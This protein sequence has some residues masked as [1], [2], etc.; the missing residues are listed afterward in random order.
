MRGK[1]SARDCRPIPRASISSTWVRTSI[2]PWWR[3]GSTGAASR[4]GSVSASFDSYN[5]GVM[6]K[7]IIMGI[8]GCGKGTQAKLLCDRY[9][10]VHISIGDIFRWHIANHTKLAA[11]INRII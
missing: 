5:L 2:Q 10:F 11:K 7:Y 3:S 8:Q 1:A 6:Y 4:N 9:D